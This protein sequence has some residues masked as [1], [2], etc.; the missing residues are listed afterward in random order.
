MNFIS[1]ESA[2]LQELAPSSAGQEDL[3][4]WDMC[5]KSEIISMCFRLSKLSENPVQLLSREIILQGER[6]ELEQ[7]QLQSDKTLEY[8]LH[9]ALDERRAARPHFQSR[10]AQASL[11]YGNMKRLV[12][13]RLTCAA[14]P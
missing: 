7:Q 13:F 14:T 2:H 6:F 5:N 1:F 9:I 8:Q 10:S 12:E 3:E 4:S 11:A